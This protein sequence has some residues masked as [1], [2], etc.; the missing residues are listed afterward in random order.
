[1][2]QEFLAQVQTTPS[3]N[4]NNNNNNNDDWCSENNNHNKNKNKR[5]CFSATQKRNLKHF[6]GFKKHIFE[7]PKQKIITTHN[8]YYSFNQIDVT[9]PIKCKELE[10]LIMESKKLKHK[11]FI[12]NKHLITNQIQKK[13]N[14]IP[15]G[16]KISVKLPKTQY[17]NHISDNDKNKR[18]KEKMKKLNNAIQNIYYDDCID[19]KKEAIQHLDTQIMDVYQK[20]NRFINNK[21]EKKKK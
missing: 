16:Q 15:N 14:L 2:S 19:I 5:R 10:K 13:L 4:K 8:N 6:K 9:I 7:T 20:A 1:M 17:S 12:K 18:E 3:P 11:L 21:L